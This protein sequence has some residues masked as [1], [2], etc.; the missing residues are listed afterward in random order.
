MNG[1]R[2]KEQN[3]ET[4][5]NL[6]FTCQPPALHTFIVTQIATNAAHCKHTILLLNTE[7]LGV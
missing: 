6:A 3:S 5:N 2:E 1:S 7:K 4:E